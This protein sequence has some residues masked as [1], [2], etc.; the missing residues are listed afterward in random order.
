MVPR[1]RE[2]QRGAKRR[3]DIH[4]GDFIPD[5]APETECGFIV[6]HLEPQ[7]SLTLQFNFPSTTELATAA[8][9]KA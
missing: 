9:G 8:E 1:I 4:L 5:G 6:Q 3:C 2:A 7:R